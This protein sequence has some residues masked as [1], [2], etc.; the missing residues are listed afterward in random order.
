MRLGRVVQ[1]DAAVAVGHR[2][3]AAEAEPV[4]QDDLLQGGD[5]DGDEQMPRHASAPLLIVIT[6]GRAAPAGVSV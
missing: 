5:A 4:A 2:H 3:R 6:T 1:Q